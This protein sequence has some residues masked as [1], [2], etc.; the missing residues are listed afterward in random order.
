MDD[1]K[2]N[3]RICVVGA[4]HGG[5]AMAAHLALLGFPVRL[6]NRSEARISRSWRSA[7]RLSSRAT[8]RMHPMGSPS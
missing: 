8:S 5:S 2:K 1:G 4:G 7:D 6:F 3:L